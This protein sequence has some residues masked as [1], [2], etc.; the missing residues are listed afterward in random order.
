[1]TARSSSTE[2]A[3]AG[4]AAEQADQPERARGVRSVIIALIVSA[5]LSSAFGASMN[6]PIPLFELQYLT[7]ATRCSC[8]AAE[9]PVSNTTRKGPAIDRWHFFTERL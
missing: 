1:M 7:P 3:L 8:L 6:R 4:G 5:R 9:M 2:R